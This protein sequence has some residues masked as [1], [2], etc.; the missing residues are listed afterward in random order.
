ML[1]ENKSVSSK[2][3]TSDVAQEREEAAGNHSTNV[4]LNVMYAIT[5]MNVL[6]HSVRVHACGFVS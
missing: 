1:E 6:S 4:N 3:R 5:Q 2:S